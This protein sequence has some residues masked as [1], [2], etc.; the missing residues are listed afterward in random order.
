MD[1]SA[2]DSKAPT[3][4]RERK[5]AR[6]RQMISVVALGLFEVQ[7]FEH[8]TIE[9]IC[10]RAEVAHRTFF[11]YYPTKESLLFN[12]DFGNVIL[13]AFAAAPAE[14]DLFPALEHALTVSEGNL[15]DPAE[16]TARR[17][18]LRRRFMGIRAVH[19]YGV[20]QIDAVT[21]RVATI[22]AER[23]RVDPREDFRPQALG[24][25]L[26]AMSRRRVIDGIDPGSL[27]VWADT[28]RALCP[29]EPDA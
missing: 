10:R 27:Q 22:A 15:E 18:A 16:H 29:A 20:A 26:A 1:E 14:L 19:D 2:G 9:Q 21:H 11:R 4:L 28:F 12:G 23:L 17:E 5:K 24:A 6:T 13:E 7:G 8:T 3:G 25:L